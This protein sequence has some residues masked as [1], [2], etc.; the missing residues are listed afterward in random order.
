MQRWEEVLGPRV[1]GPLRRLLSPHPPCACRRRTP[2]S[3]PRAVPCVRSLFCRRDM[4]RPGEHGSSLSG[5]LL[6]LCEH[7]CFQLLQ[8]FKIMTALM[9]GPQVWLYSPLWFGTEGEM[10]SVVDS[11]EM[12]PEGVEG[13]WAPTSVAAGGS[14]QV[15]SPGH[16]LGLQS[17]AIRFAGASAFEN[18]GSDLPAVSRCPLAFHVRCG[19]KL[20]VPIPVPPPRLAPGPSCGT[21]VSV[22]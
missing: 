13:P 21:W 7:C 14:L 19:R 8:F 1:Q 4:R 11:Q 5:F 9:L 15:Q 18:S 17:T 12:V 6:H 2:E 22:R 20:G 16:P 3:A 10:W